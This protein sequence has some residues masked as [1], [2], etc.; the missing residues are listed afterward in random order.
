MPAKILT[1]TQTDQ[2]LLRVA[3]TRAVEWQS[4]MKELA[5]GVLPAELALTDRIVDLKERLV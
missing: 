1:I 4:M 2:D 5:G 3:L